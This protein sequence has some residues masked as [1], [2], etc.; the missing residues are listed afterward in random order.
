MRALGG[1]CAAWCGWS[2]TAPGWRVGWGCSTSEGARC[3]GY[4]RRWWPAAGRWWRGRSGA[5]VPGRGVAGRAGAR[6]AAAGGLPRT[7]GRAGVDGRG[8]PTA[9]AGHGRRGP[10]GLVGAGPRRRRDHRAVDRDGRTAL[11]AGLGTG[12]APGAGGRAAPAGSRP[13]RPAPVG[14]GG[15]RRPGR[16]GVG[17]PLGDEAVPAHLVVA[18]RSRAEHAGARSRSWARWRIRVEQG[19]DRG[20]VAP[21]AGLGRCP[22]QGLGIPDTDGITVSPRD[23]DS[24]Q[25]G[26][27]TRGGSW[28]RAR[29]GGG[30]GPGAPGRRTRR[31]WRRRCGRWSGNGGGDQRLDPV[32]GGRVAA[33]G[34]RTPKCGGFHRGRGALGG[35]GR[36]RGGT[37][38]TS[39]PSR[40]PP[41]S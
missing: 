24:P 33:G 28:C 8:P 7:G 5:G 14:R 23:R 35:W 26:R 3:W 4:R 10:R 36:G 34:H 31:R 29:G 38:A 22:G 40:V 37:L 12:P 25:P 32:D 15:R 13:R 1:S 41:R 21:A 27:G 20:P 30:V 6:P 39:G 9:G 16:A 19:R 17:D 11:R 2:P 18:G